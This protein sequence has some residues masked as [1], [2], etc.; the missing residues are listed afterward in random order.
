MLLAH[1][2][3]RKI[4]SEFNVTFSS[5]VLSDE[6]HE[7]FILYSISEN[8]LFSSCRLIYAF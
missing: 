1:I 4:A 2:L 8:Y 3:F 6:I 7:E 5:F